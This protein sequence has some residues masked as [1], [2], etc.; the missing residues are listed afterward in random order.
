MQER[1]KKFDY[2]TFEPSIDIDEA[3][4]AD[5]VR[6]AADLAILPASARRALLIG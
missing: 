2:F 1:L 4:L 6:R 3:I 5:Y